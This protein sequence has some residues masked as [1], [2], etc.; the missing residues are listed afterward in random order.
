MK[1]EGTIS[2]RSRRYG[3]ASLSEMNVIPLVDVVLVLL[4]IFMITAQAME[5]GLEIEVPKVKQD[6]ASAEDLPVISVTRN[7]DLYLADQPV[8]LAELP[9]VLRQRYGKRGNA[10]YLRADKAATWDTAV[11]VIDALGRAKIE[12]RVVTTAQEDTRRRR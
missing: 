11:Q 3:P 6:R 4:I 2:G 9:D 10:A 8:R 7:G 5:F 1:I 12:V